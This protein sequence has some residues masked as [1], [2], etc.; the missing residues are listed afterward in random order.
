[1]TNNLCCRVSADIL[2]SQLSGSWDSPAMATPATLA[3]SDGD[4]RAKP[5][6][7]GNDFADFK[8]RKEIAEARQ[9]GTM[10][11]ELDVESGK[12]SVARLRRISAPA[13]PSAGIA[14]VRHRSA[15][16]PH[17]PPMPRRP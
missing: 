13:P 10:A 4:L 9:A 5:Q 12:A 1:M 11:P 16:P 15:G 8:K 7:G 2:E 14:R 3:T 6:A 17:A